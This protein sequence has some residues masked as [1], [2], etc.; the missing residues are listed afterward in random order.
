MKKIPIE[1]Q[2]PEVDNRLIWMA[3]I[4]AAWA[5]T[6]IVVGLVVSFR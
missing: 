3:V 1:D 6:M 4:A 2:P 5:V